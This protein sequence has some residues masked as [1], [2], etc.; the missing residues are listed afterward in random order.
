ML[1]WSLERRA[2]ERRPPAGRRTAR[3]S[4]CSTRRATRSRA[5]SSAITSSSRAAS[6]ATRARTTCAWA[7]CRPTSSIV[8]PS[9]TRSSFQLDTQISALESYRLSL[10]LLLTPSRSRRARHL[11]LAHD[12]LVPPPRLDARQHAPPPRPVERHG[13]PVVH[14]AQEHELPVAEL[15]RRQG[16]DCLLRRRGRQGVGVGP[17]VGASHAFPPRLFRRATSSR[18]HLC[19]QVSCVQH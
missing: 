7:S 4:R 16:G 11:P 19:A 8:R 3:R 13:R 15:H 2:D 17:R 6:T 18:A 14:R 9:L 1:N 5:S 12:R 10:V